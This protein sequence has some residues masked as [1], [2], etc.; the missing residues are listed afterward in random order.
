MVLVSCSCNSYWTPNL[1]T[2]LHAVRNYCCLPSKVSC[3]SCFQDNCMPQSMAQHLPVIQTCVVIKYVGL[4]TLIL[5]FLNYDN[6]HVIG[7]GSG[8]GGVIAPT[9]KPKSPMNIIKTYTF[10]IV[11][12][13]VAPP[14]FILFLRSCM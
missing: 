4:A 14:T 10:Y 8:G 1:R 7:V 2:K 11:D 12:L 9:K 13:N 3:P 5:S 6:I